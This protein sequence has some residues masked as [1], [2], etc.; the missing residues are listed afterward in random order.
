MVL[1]ANIIS[2]QLSSHMKLVHHAKVLKVKGQN[3]W[4]FKYL[5]IELNTGYLLLCIQLLAD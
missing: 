1:Q 2:Q 4:N 3:L 5:V